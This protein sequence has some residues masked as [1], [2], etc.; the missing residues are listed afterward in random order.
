[1]QHASGVEGRRV[2]V[3]TGFA[4]N[5]TLSI[6]GA[7]GVDYLS[8]PFNYNETTFFS[9]VTLPDQNYTVTMAADSLGGSGSAPFVKLNLTTTPPTMVYPYIYNP[10]FTNGQYT[11]WEVN[12]SGFGSSPLGINYANS[13]SVQCFYGSPWANYGNEYFATTYSC[14]A[15]VS[16]GN[17]TSEPFRVS[18]K[19]PFLNFKMISPDDSL[20]YVEVFQVGGNAS[21]TGHFNTYNISL[22][23]NIESTFEN[24]SLPLTTLVNKAVRIKI[25]ALT[26]QP[27]RYVAIGGFSLS[28]LPDTDSG[29]GV[30]VNITR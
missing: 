11:G 25:V 23:P 21:I 12:G 6:V 27:N 19:A 14:G 29:V 8:G 4:H 16:P 28:G 24:V 10:N 9:N 2:W 17:L 1:M 3:Y 15:S 30:Q 18:S 22:G 13:D 26:V 20:I 7:D 5:T